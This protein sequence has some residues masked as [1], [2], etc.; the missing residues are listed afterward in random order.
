MSKEKMS[1]N[2][3]R[4]IKAD[5]KIVEKKISTQKM[6][7]NKGRKI[8]ADGKKCRKVGYCNITDKKS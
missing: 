2:K 4:K 1:K 7:K 3:C 8:N 5:G 6:S